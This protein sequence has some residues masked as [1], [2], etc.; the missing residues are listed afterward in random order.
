MLVKKR[1]G[2]VG[3]AS[4]F[5]LSVWLGN[6]RREGT[7]M[8]LILVWATPVLLMLWSLAYQFL[9]G[10]P[11][12]KTWLPIWLPTLYLWIVDTLALRRGT[13][14][15]VSGTKLGIYIWPN[16]EIEEAA[17][18]LLTNTL[19]VWGS[20][21]FDNAIA[22]LDAF[23]D[24]FPYLPKVPSPM[25]MVQSLLLPASRYDEARLEGL[26]NALVVLAKKSRS[27]YL[28]SGVFTG[29]LRIDLILLYAVCRLADDLIDNAPNAE[30]AE[31]WIKNFSRV[32]DASYADPK[33]EDKIREALTPFSLAAQ[34]VLLQLP[35]DKLPSGPLYALLDGF[36]IDLQFL[37]GTEADRPPIKDRNDLERYASCVA[38]TIGELCLSLVYAHDPDRAVTESTTKKKCLAAGACMGRALQYINIVRDVNTDAEV[39]RCYLP[40][41]WFTHPSPGKRLDEILPLRKKLLAIAFQ[42][43]RDNRDAIETL[44]PYARDGI[45][46]AVES[47]VEIGRVLRERI[48]KGQPLD[49]AG[50]GRRGRASVPRMRRLWVGWKSMAGWRGST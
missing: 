26:R 50:G 25:L 22:I 48:Q 1:L 9:L 2:Q 19:V 34:S 8:R 6:S 4:S 23:P 38:A 37:D 36:R 29:R 7:Y 11:S 12:S 30:E 41:D 15:I 27:F 45:R 17:F 44:P 14:S 43:Y 47:Y 16:L 31:E 42:G 5:L 46:V 28:A 24:L 49:F 35:T 10:L 20:C 13:W 39:G 21:A 33:D 18:F 40:A 3:L 32:F